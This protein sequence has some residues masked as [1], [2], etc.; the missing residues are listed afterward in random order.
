MRFILG[1]IIG[2]ILVPLLGLAYLTYGNVPVAVSDPAFP[3][4]R[5]LV[6]IPLNARIQKE[7]VGTH[8]Q[9]D[10]PTLVAGARIYTERCAFCHGFHGKRAAIGDHM[11]PDAPP[12]L[13]PHP[14]DPNVVGVS[15]DPP[16]ET[17]WKVLNGI[18]LTGMPSFKAQLSDEQMWQVTI[19]LAN[20]NKPM[21]PAALDILT[22]APAPPADAP[23]HPATT[24]PPHEQ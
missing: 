19:F 1:L 20:A 21:P 3:H 11:Y 22:R 23:S 8:M 18:R 13:E 17:Y 2:I 24:E 5:Q 9:P 12:L 7:I 14:N 10:Q 15:D 6:H 4:E 16:G